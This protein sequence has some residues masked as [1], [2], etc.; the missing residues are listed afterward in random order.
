MCIIYIIII[1]SKFIYR[2]RELSSEDRELLMTCT[3]VDVLVPVIV[4]SLKRARREERGRSITYS[5]SNCYVSI[6]TTYIG[7]ITSLFIYDSVCYAKIR[8]YTTTPTNVYG[9]LHYTNIADTTCTVANILPLNQL[10]RPLA[11]ALDTNDLWV[12][13]I[14]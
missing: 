4:N 14:L 1:I 7:Y 12:L 5:T 13:N 2:S 10:S 9:L 3:E 6:N 8:Q 11:V